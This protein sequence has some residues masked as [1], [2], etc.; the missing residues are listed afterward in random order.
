[1]VFNSLTFF[2]F[3]VIFFNAYW[4]LNKYTGVKLRNL[5]TLVASYFFYG[6]WDYRFL[7]LIF[8][9]SVSDYILG[10]KIYN[11]N[12]HKLKKIFLVTSIIINLGI[13]GFFKYYNFFIDSFLELASLFNVSLS[14]YTLSIILPV[15][16]SFYTFQTLSYTI[17]IYYGK[18]KPTREIVSFFTFVAFFPQLVAG[19]IERASS[20]LPQFQERKKFSYDNAVAGLRLVLWGLFKKIVI[21]DNLG[22]LVDV[23][24][25]PASDFTGV[26]VF[27]GG[28]LFAFQVYCD[29]SG[30]SD[31]AIG[32]SKMLGFELM[33]NF[34]TPFFSASFSE[35][36]RRW[37]ISLS[38]WF[39]DY[40]YIPLGGSKK[41]RFRVDLNIFIT[42][43][44]SG[45]WHG[46]HISFVLWGSL[47]GIAL[48][49]EKYLKIKVKPWIAIPFVFFIFSLFLLPFRAVDMSHLYDLLDRLTVLN[50]SFQEILQ[51]SNALLS[52]NK[53]FAL[54]GVIVIFMIVEYKIGLSDF[55]SWI[56]KRKRPFRISTYLILIITIAL[57]VNL[58]VKP[59]FIY[60]QF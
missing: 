44:L 32:I 23:I 43:L 47:H 31:I 49:I 29:F 28:V 22:L 46:A 20:L 30:Y 17:D 15:G 40:V 12:E 13:L 5:F 8:I 35:L 56:S 26:S 42:F 18:L 50:F 4:F 41:S 2:V 14:F 34:K 59:Y 6:W 11:S 39:R 38:T 53:S 21:A 25:D 58:D 7:A 37:H 27:M 57:L 36:W 52:A 33:I 1:M 24:F 60:F 16:I 19:P 9:S 55:S 51:R 54:L 48:I 10:L 3:F 45:L